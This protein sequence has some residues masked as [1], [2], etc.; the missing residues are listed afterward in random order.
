MLAKIK[1]TSE[2]LILQ[3]A[4][5]LRPDRVSH[6]HPRGGERQAPFVRTHKVGR[7]RNQD[8]LDLLQ[9]GVAPMVRKADPID[10]PSGPQR[11]NGGLDPTGSRPQS[12]PSRL[13]LGKIPPCRLEI[14]I[15]RPRV[16]VAASLEVP[17]RRRPQ[18][19]NILLPPIGQ[20]VPALAA[21]RGV[22]RDLVL[23]ETPSREEPLGI[24]IK[25]VA[26]GKNEAAKPP[27][28]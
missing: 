17:P 24:T 14:G 20:V 9:K 11:E 3:Q 13:C 16:G 21:G 15:Q 19:Q 5:N 27:V 4:Q 1:F 10:S 28:S 23:G 22:A 6:P 12:F 8:R 25:R 18:G 2:I 26:V 7:D